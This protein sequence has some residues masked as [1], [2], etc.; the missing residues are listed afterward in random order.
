MREERVVA[1]SEDS[2]QRLP[3]AAIGSPTI[4][5]LEESTARHGA[6]SE[7]RRIDSPA[8]CERIRSLQRSPGDADARPPEVPSD[9][10]VLDPRDKPPSPAYI[11]GSSGDND[12]RP[13]SYAPRVRLARANG[14]EQAQLIL[15]D[16]R[17][18]AQK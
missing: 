10:P 18:E 11:S 17:M 13:A 16:T 2:T 7:G 3:R 8:V 9:Q 15:V 14:A 4:R 5:S 1:V 6:A 12:E